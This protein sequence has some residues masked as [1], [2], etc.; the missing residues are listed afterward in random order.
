MF[1]EG[2]Q[3]A[4]RAERTG[5]EAQGLAVEFDERMMLLE[6]VRA[7][8][9]RDEAHEELFGAAGV[10]ARREAEAVRDA[11]VVGVHDDGG[12][13]RVEKLT[14]SAETMGPAP[15][16][17]SIQ[18]RIFRCGTWRGSRGELAGAGGDLLECE[19]EAGSFFFREGDVG[20]DGLDLGDGCFAEVGP[21]GI[22]GLEGIGGGVGGFGARARGEDGVDELRERVP[23]L[24][25]GWQAVVLGEKLVD[26]GEEG[27]VDR[28]GWGWDVGV[29]EEAIGHAGSDEN[30]CRKIE[31]VSLVKQAA[32]LCQD[33]FQ[34]RCRE[35][36]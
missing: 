18:A 2:Q 34:D 28:L 14:T 10:R 29:G 32:D 31:A 33:I 25:E 1:A 26:A 13:R 4:L 11:E 15:G 9:G 35:G 36:L 27:K 21:G 20:D 5:E 17:C 30:R 12:R 16:N 3:R 22:A 23:A 6:L 24:A 8:V 19:L 7:P